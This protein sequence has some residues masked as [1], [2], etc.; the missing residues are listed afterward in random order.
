ML[1]TIIISQKKVVNKNS[2]YRDN[3]MT[4]DVRIP[5]VVVLWLLSIIYEIIKVKNI[6]SMKFQTTKTDCLFISENA[7]HW[8]THYISSDN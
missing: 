5:D 6:R 1:L 4:S 3:A 2:Q 8:S 7:V